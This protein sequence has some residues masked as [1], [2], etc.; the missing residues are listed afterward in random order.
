VNAIMNHGVAG[1][2]GVLDQL[3]KYQLLKKWTLLHKISYANITDMEQSACT[4]KNLPLNVVG[5]ICIS[6]IEITY[7]LLSLQCLG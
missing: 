5:T 1:K 7:T 3:S 4:W 2:T 6:P